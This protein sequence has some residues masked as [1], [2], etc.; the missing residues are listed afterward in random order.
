MPESLQTCHL[1]FRTRPAEK[2]NRPLHRTS[3]SLR[4]LS[5]NGTSGKLFARLRRLGIIAGGVTIFASLSLSAAS[6]QMN[7]TGMQFPPGQTAQFDRKESVLDRFRAH[8]GKK[9]Q[10]ARDALFMRGDAVFQQEPAVILSE[11]SSLAHITLRLPA[12]T[13]EP[14]KFSISKGHCVSAK[15]T[16]SGV[17]ILVIL[18]ARGTLTTSVTVNFAGSMTEYPLSVAPP[19]HL[20]DRQKADAAVIDYVTTANQ[21]ATSRTNPPRN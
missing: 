2:H 20:F 1:F 7:Q 12:R 3:P 19:L 10:A 17:W 14:P 11:G 8:S 21:L 15:M 13:G 4:N 5:E 9:T 18:P 6:A 16:D